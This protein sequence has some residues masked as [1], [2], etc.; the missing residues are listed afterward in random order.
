MPF[1]FF[2]QGP[3]APHTFASDRLILVEGIDDAIFFEAILG[4][5]GVTV[6]QVEIRS[7]EGYSNF[8]SYLK[9]LAKAPAV[10][11][12]QLIKFCLIADA[13]DS[14]DDRVKELRSYLETA[15]F[16]APAAGTFD[17]S[18][19]PEVGIY[20][21][22]DNKAAGELED[23]FIESLDGDPR[24][25]EA[26]SALNKFDPENN[27]TKRS[28]RLIQILLALSEQ[29]LCA[30]IGRGLR[31]GAVE[32]PKIEIEKLENFLNELLS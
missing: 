16:G 6:G 29:R 2:T 12:G 22:P 21:L 26:S 31:N 14:F 23:L 25:N 7:V 17:N 32:L 18:K 13:D 5:L 27:W 30:G 15:G 24:L 20:V 8:Q 9:A 19:T 3:S 10:T 4:Q 11:S 1:K 28:K